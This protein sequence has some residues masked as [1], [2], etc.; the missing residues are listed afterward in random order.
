MGSAA[1]RSRITNPAS[2]AAPATNAVMAFGPTGAAGLHQRPGNSGRAAGDQR[3]RGQVEPGRGPAAVRQEDRG[4]NGRD[5]SDR[6]VDPE[7]PVPV[8]ALDHGAA[9]QWAARDGQP[10]DPAPDADDGS[11][12]GGREGAAQDRQAERG[13]GG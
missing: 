8:Q 9:D 6:H 5:Q 7:D 12:P 13:D 11:A 3:H 10:T 2:R 1:R 4:Q